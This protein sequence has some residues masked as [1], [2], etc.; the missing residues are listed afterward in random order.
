[1][2]DLIVG[3]LFTAHKW[4][5]IG[6]HRTERLRA[7]P[8]ILQGAEKVHHLPEGRPQMPGGR[9][10]DL[11]GHAVKAF[12]QQLAQ[13][14]PRAI[15]RQHVQVV[16][17]KIA[18]PMGS[19]D[20]AAVNVMQPVIRGHFA[21][22]VEDQPA[23]RISLVGVGVH[24]PIRGAQVFIHRGHRGYQRLPQIAFQTRF[25]PFLAVENV[26]FGHPMMAGIHQLRFDQILD[27]LDLQSL[28]LH[29]P[30]DDRLHHRLGEAQDVGLAFRRQG[31]AR[32]KASV[33]LESGFDGEENAGFVESGHAPV[34]LAHGKLPPLKRVQL[35]QPELAVDLFMQHVR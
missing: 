35:R 24:P 10:F 14:P 16:N 12:P 20:L 1:M 30:R 33:R 18:F 22:D 15:P 32:R 26:P 17:V 29:G 23:E 5:Q 6:I 11:V 19:L 34:A 31:L 28:A 3:K 2:A 13:G 25:A 7:R 4:R 9:G 21:G 27:G 8:F